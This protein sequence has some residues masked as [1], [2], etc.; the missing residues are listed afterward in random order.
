MATGSGLCMV[1]AA[2]EMHDPI[3]VS[4]VM[5]LAEQAVDRAGVMEARVSLS[6]G[7]GDVEVSGCRGL[8]VVLATGG[9][10]HIALDLAD[11]ARTPLAV[12]GL[13]YANSASSLAELAPLLRRRAALW[14]I[15]GLDGRGVESMSHVVA[16]VHAAS[17]V[18]GSRIL[19]LG[20]PSPWLVND[21]HGLVDRLG[22]EVVVV[23]PERV[24]EAFKR[25]GSWPEALELLDKAESADLSPGEP[26]RSLRV[27]RAVFDLARGF[28]AVSPACIRFLHLTGANAC[29]AHA[30]Q[31]LGGVVVGCEGDVVATLS[32]LLASA[33]SGRP[34][35]QANL[36]GAWDGRLL[37]A[38]C[39]APLEYASRFR[40]RRH[41]ITGGSVTVQASIRAGYVSF[42]RFSPVGDRAFIGGGRVIDGSPGFEMQ[43]ETQLLVEFDSGVDIIARGIG[44]H[45]AVVPGRH[46]DA[47]RVAVEALGLEPVV[48]S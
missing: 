44:N 4:R 21:Y 2:S 10:E 35:W 16:G 22:A 27:A 26:G 5:R 24:Y 17:K 31:G 7:P 42:F 9:T 33:V 43:C 12:I 18:R 8:V 34:A 1:V 45:Y 48:L 29:L 23:E 11:R 15:P 28:D 20:E 46:V 32:L 19:L 25:A 13:P 30:L 39:S 38:H 41:F 6:T 40:L 47:M 36:A 14:L 3:Y 37:L